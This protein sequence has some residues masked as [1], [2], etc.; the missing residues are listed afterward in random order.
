LRIR[1]AELGAVIDTIETALQHAR[2][3]GL[4][5]TSRHRRV[6]AQAA[7]AAHVLHAIAA[8]LGEPS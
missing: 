1:L 2:H 8:R 6:A 3:A 5:P 4:Q 7:A